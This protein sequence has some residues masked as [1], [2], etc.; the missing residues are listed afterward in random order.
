MRKIPIIMDVDTGI[1]DAIALTVALQSDKLDIKGVTV[2]AGNQTLAKTLK[3]TLDV[4]DFLGR[5]DVPVARGAAGSLVREQIIAGE[6]H[7]ENGLGGAVLPRASIT[8]VEED[9]VDFIRK[10]LEESRE[11]ITIVPTGP[12]TNIALLLLAYPH[13]KD[14]IEKIVMMG[15]G[16]FEGNCNASS[17]FNIMADPQAA[18]VVFASGVQIV[19][20]G[21]DV[22]MKAYTTIED[23]NRVR[24][25][26]TEAG[27]FCAD[28]FMHYYNRYIA[29]SRL[30]GCAVHDAVAVAYLIAPEIIKAK[31][32]TVRVDIDGDK[33]YACTASDFRPYRDKSKDNALVC[34]DIDREAFVKIIIDACKSYK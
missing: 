23:I 27:A 13:V 6:T 10:T 4:V 2:V 8:R 5:G 14:K 19:M 22:T 34:M 26:G 3:N 12:L 31:A 17:E 7:G 16:A 33:T 20:C 18:A 24:S 15:G 9:A 11:K 32:A 29:N 28:A 30:P 1:D 25:T 21:L